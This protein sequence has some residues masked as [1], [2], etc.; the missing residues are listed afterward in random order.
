ML[1]SQNYGTQG[2]SGSK[3]QV[4]RTKCL[5]KN[6]VVISHWKLIPQLKALEQKEKMSSKRSKQKDIIK[7]KSEIN[8]VE[9]R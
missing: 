1:H 3:R 9:T 7:V 5:H 8:I 6:T 4:H 2:I